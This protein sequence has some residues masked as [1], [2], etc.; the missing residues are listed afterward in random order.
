MKRCTLQIL[1]D[2]SGNAIV[3]FAIVAPVM[4]VL[5]MGLG[6][7]LYQAYVQAIL[8]GAVQQAGR[9]SGIEGGSTTSDT[10]D[11]RVIAMVSQI[12]QNPTQSCSPSGASGA[13]WCSL[14]ENY[15][16]F[17][18][19]APEPFT[20]T[21]KNGVRDQGECF[22]D[23]NNNG[24]WDADPGISGQGGASDVALYTMTI[25]YP[26]LFPVAGLIG[27]PAQ[28]TVSAATLLKNQPYATQATNSTPTVCT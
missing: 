12:V 26:R 1:R 28:A 10:I 8:I 24:V 2:C 4:A 22:T 9:S 27:L 20:D 17:S 16:T 7:L 25:R 5:L 21:N 3:E 18:A 13:T 23:M 14:R 11:A 19:V 6:D 15:D